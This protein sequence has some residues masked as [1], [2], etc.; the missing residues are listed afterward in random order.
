MKRE[1]DQWVWRHV[2]L[3]LDDVAE[4]GGGAAV[5][6]GHALEGR[7]AT[8]QLRV[9]DARSCHDEALAI[10]HLV[11]QSARLGQQ[12]ISSHVMSD[13]GGGR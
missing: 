8:A 2:R 9:G 7:P 13:K 12:D 4:L 6:D 11:I 1:G 10:G 3:E 5:V